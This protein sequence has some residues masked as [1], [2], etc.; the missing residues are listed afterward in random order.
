M[1]WIVKPFDINDFFSWLYEKAK[2]MMDL[3]IGGQW[4]NHWLNKID[5]L[6]TMIAL[7]V[8]IQKKTE[9]LFRNQITELRKVMF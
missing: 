5:Q 2:I 3:S 4:P 1:N 9:R 7:G 8:L 6:I